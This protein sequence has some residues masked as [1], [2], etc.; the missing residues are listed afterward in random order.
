M[1]PGVPAERLEALRQALARTLTDPDFL[2]EAQRASLT[3][4]PVTGPDVSRL[5]E[6][7]LNTP[8]TTLARLRDVL[9]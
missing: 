9:Q 1:A 3:V 6:D 5:V 8:T 2:G 7:L 4:S